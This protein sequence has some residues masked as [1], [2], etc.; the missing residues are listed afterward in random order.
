MHD[1]K[2]INFKVNPLFIEHKRYFFSTAIK[3]GGFARFK[4]C[5]PIRVGNKQCKPK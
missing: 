3:D 2:E 5:F 1:L 4:P